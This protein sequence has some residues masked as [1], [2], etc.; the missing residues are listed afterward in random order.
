M[1]AFKSKNPEEALESFTKYIIKPSNY[2]NK[3]TRKSEL[4]KRFKL[5]RKY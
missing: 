1:S 5:M 3:K 2:L 4:N